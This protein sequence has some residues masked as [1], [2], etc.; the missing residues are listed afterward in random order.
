M[1]LSATASWRGLGQVF[2]LGGNQ[3]LFVGAFAGTI[4]LDAGSGTLDASGFVCPGTFEID[5]ADGT[6]TG[7]GKCIITGRDG[8]RLFARWD[9]V[10]RPLD[11]CRGGF[12]IFGGSGRFASAKGD[13]QI[14]V[15]GTVP[16]FDLDAEGPALQEFAQGLAF[17]PELV[18][19]LP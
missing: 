14:L 3:V 2:D 4:F 12:H 7:E 15:R 11:G 5:T 19:E 1:T 18:I 16:A 13:S 8:D 10:G 6:Q 9:C 17:W